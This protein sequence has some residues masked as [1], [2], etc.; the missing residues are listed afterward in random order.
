MDD[1]RLWDEEDAFISITRIH[2]PGTENLQAQFDSITQYLT[3]LASANEYKRMRWRT[4]YTIE[5]SDM[6]LVSKAP[7]LQVLSHWTLLATKTKLVGNAYTYFG[8]PHHWVDNNAVLLPR[9]LNT[10]T[11]DFLSMRFSIKGGKINGSLAEI[12]D[13]L[14]QKC[15][16]PAFRVAG[17]EDVIICG[18]NVPAVNLIRLYQKWYT[19]DGNVRICFRDIITRLGAG[20]DVVPPPLED[21]DYSHAE[22]K[23]E[24]YSLSVLEKVRNNILPAVDIQ[25]ERWLRPLVA[26]TNAL[27]HMSQSATLDEIVFL[28]LPGLN[29]F[30]DNI[31]D[32]NQRATNEQIFQRFAELCIH[33]TEHLMR[34]EGQL[35]HRLEMRPLTYDMP[36]FVLECATAFLL[37][38]SDSLTA[39]DG[40]E[41]ENI[42]FLLVP[43]TSTTVFTD[44]LFSS[45]DETPGLLQTRV[46]FDLLYKPRYLIP[47]LCHEMAH[48]VGEKIRL[49]K[50]RYELFLHSIA[51]ELIRYF[52]DHVSDNSGQFQQFLINEVL[53]KPLKVW[54]QA[55]TPFENLEI[56]E[57]PLDEIVSLIRRNLEALFSREDPSAYIELFRDYICSPY[58]GAQLHGI[59]IL[60][61]GDRF[62]RFSSR[63][64]DLMAYYRESYA[65][66][67]M[68]FLLEL[69]PLEYL[70]I[71]AGQWD[72]LTDGMLFQVYACM[73]VSG[74][75]LTEILEAF[76][77]WGLADG[78]EG[79]RRNEVH[80]TIC[81]FDQMV[82]T[83]SA[84]RY[85]I[86]YLENCWI[87][88][89]KVQLGSLKDED[90]HNIKGI[91]DCLLNIDKQTK[92]SEILKIIAKGRHKILKRLVPLAQ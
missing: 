32:E 30:W 60:A 71:A 33:T 75:S 48:Y 56:A 14:G 21:G 74:H 69:Q 12:R 63:L 5:L 7:N 40:A 18:Q 62:D 10:D 55:N 49:R 76:E 58:H 73:S 39:A 24:K 17:N 88:F 53:D 31:L 43:S 29:A 82:R 20:W 27:V 66:L 70:K 79:K 28:I 64:D 44:E 72:T 47:S 68:L 86:Q 78:I 37:L 89:R 6:V 51:L 4:Y 61:L 80:E 3:S 90:F 11:I 36:V 38:L 52:F 19:D 8:I 57:I 67:C 92:Y 54:V 91:Y 1:S 77:T 84:E 13:C 50:Q 22:T 85:V 35:S 42:S 15:T 46:P 87:N 65:D 25:K 2:F 45:T 83:N 9:S 23:L 34:A 16:T 41:A 59:P 81:S 26:L